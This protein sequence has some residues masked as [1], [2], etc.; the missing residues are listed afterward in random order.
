MM[1]FMLLMAYE[2]SISHMACA[3]AI[4]CDIFNT[5]EQDSCINC[6]DNFLEDHAGTVNFFG[7][8]FIKDKINNYTCQQTMKAAKEHEIYKCVRG[9]NG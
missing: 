4:Q 5:S 3:K 2:E 7:K 1:L 8:N 9:N 6:V